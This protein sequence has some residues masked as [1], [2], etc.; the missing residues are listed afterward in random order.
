MALHHA[1]RL[2]QQRMVGLSGLGGKQRAQPRQLAREQHALGKAQRMDRLN[3]DP[4]IVRQRGGHAPAGEHHARVS[5]V[6]QQRVQ[7]LA[8]QRDAPLVAVGKQRLQVVQHQQHGL[9]L[10]Q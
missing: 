2:A 7:H 3:L 10:E 9:L 8:P 6:C 4:L 1:Q 5:L